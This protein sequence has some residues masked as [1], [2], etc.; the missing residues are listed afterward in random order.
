M[1]AEW[2]NE[3]RLGD[4][5]Y[6]HLVRD[7]YKQL[8]SSRYANSIV[9]K[10]MKR[11]TK[12]RDLDI[13]ESI[14]KEYSPRIKPRKNTLVIHLRVGDVVKRDVDFLLKQENLIYTKPLS[15]YKDVIKDYTK[16][17]SITLV[18]GGCF[19]KN[20]LPLS[21]KFISKIKELYTEM[22]Y[23]VNVRIGKNA[24]DDFVFM[25]RAKHFIPGGGKFS[26]LINQLHK[27][28][29]QDN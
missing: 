16:I 24:D 4:M 14:I 28:N 18:A 21:K 11:T 8:Y 13:L 17:K 9:S 1:R 15:Y 12:S 27:K 22:G 29:E 23:N 10:Y 3:Y 2:N 25:S 6:S 7:K 26:N 19:L 5:I 20:N